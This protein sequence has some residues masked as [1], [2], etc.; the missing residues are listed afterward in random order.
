M[1]ER[2]SDAVKLVLADDHTV[3]RSALRML[4]EA[5][6]GFEVI[7]EAGDAETALA[8]VRTQAPDV[9]VLDLNMPGRPSLDILPELAAEAARTGVVILT[10]QN[11][12]EFA[13]RALAAGVLGYVLKEAADTELVAAVRAAARRETYLQPSLGAQLARGRSAAESE[14]LTERELEVLELIALGHTSAEIA[15]RLKIGLRTVEGHR[16]NI[17]SKLDATSRADLVRAALDRGMLGSR[18]R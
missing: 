12:T 14:P 10:M 3:V 7:A 11:E 16:A 13:E 17:Q 5:E 4:L 6:P 8:Q 18:A 1:P 2:E 9:L 15:E